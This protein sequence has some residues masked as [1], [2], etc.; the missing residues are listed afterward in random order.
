MRLIRVAGDDQRG[1]PH[2]VE[3]YLVQDAWSID[4]CE[5]LG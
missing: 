1:H 2:L 3:G 4:F 5:L